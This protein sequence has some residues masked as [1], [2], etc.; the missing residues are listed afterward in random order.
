MEHRRLPYQPALDGLRALAVGAVI[1]YHLNVGWS[2][3]GFL[4]VDMFFVLSGFL[5]TSLLLAEWGKSGKIRFGAFWA[6]RA[7][8]LLPAL[9][10]MLAAVTAYAAATLPADQLGQLRGDAL[11]TLFY[12]ANWRFIAVGQSYFALF[13]TASPLRHMWSLAIEEQFYLVWPLVVFACLR[14]ARGRRW[15]LGAVCAV[16]MVASALTMAAVY[17]SSNPSR[18]FY[19]TDSRAQLILIGGLL[20]IVLARW[21]P[22]STGSRALVHGA[23]L[24]GM[25]YCFWAWAAISDV[26]SWMYGG[27]FFVFGLAV[28][29]V[30]A[31]VM[32]PARGRSTLQAALS[33]PPLVWVGRISYGL[34]LW[35]W[36]IIVFATQQRTGL[37][38]WQLALFQVGLTFL[39]AT[40][41]FYL[42][43]LPIRTGR[44]PWRRVGVVL[45]TAF[46]STGL[47]IVL[48]TVNAA[49]LPAY[50]RTP[51]NVLAEARRGPMQVGAN[52]QTNRVV[53]ATNTPPRGLLVVGDSLAVSLLPGLERVAS[54]DRLTLATGAVDGCGLLTGSPLDPNNQLYP[55]SDACSNAVPLIESRAVFNS[56]PSIVLWVSGAWDERDRIVNGQE[57]QIGTAQGDKVMLQLMDES[58]H[59]LTANGAHLVIVLT[60]PEPPNTS[61]AAD[62]SRNRRTVELDAVLRQYAKIHGIPVV[63][64]A[65]LLCAKGPPCPSVVEHLVMRPDGYHFSADA[66]FW[67]AQRI[68]PRLLVGGTTTV[69]TGPRATN[70]G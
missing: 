25:A 34:Y 67:I 12:G 2:P 44:M 3:G 47:A 19:G 54:A 68:A 61:L 45:P 49:P 17:T 1:A 28:A 59:R 9:L 50:L 56:N 58:V 27:G 53:T 23:G 10:L 62:P 7:R 21:S 13:S 29:A 63:A 30:I 14:L 11:S 33:V 35:H 66:S 42:V 46:V 38:G 57:I 52:G 39:I 41:S 4:G 48:L 32:Q 64:L 31:S 5:I 51:T 40:L 8:R 22:R 43:E 24:I 16:G 18:A 55:W 6:G 69:A 37:S 70:H 15:L 60:A 65:P 20:A 36:P 26:A